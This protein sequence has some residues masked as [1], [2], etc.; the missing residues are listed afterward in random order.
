MPMFDQFGSNGGFLVIMQILSALQATA[1]EDSRIIRSQLLLLA[2]TILSDAITYSRA[3]LE[4]FKQMPGWDK[5]LDA[6]RFA[7]E[8]SARHGVVSRTSALLI[9]L[10][11]GDV[12]GGVQHFGTVYQKIRELQNLG[13]D[14]DA[15]RKQLTPL[16]Q[17]T[18]LHPRAIDGALNMAASDQGTI[19]TCYALLHDLLDEPRNIA[20]LS[21][22]ATVSRMLQ[23]WI[24]EESCSSSD[25]KLISAWRENLLRILLRDGIRSSDDLRSVFHQLQTHSIN[26]QLRVLNVMRSIAHDAYRPSALTF[27]PTSSPGGGG[28]YIASLNRAFPE[29]PESS[30]G[31]TMQ[32]VIRINRVQGNGIL[33]LVTLS[34]SLRLGMDLNSCQLIYHTDTTVSIPRSTLALR[35]W[36]HIVLTHARSK[37][38]SPAV[39]HVY[40]NG[41]RLTSFPAAYPASRDQV[42]VLLGSAPNQPGIIGAASASAS[43]SLSSFF[44]LDGVLPSSIPLLLTVLP[45][46]YKGNFQGRL[47][48]FL[49]PQG[50]TRMQLRL[51][52]LAAATANSNGKQA[53]PTESR[54]LTALRKALFDTG[55]EILPINRFYAH[56]QAAQTLRTTS[57]VFLQNKTLPSMH[58]TA[59]L[60][61]HHA[62]IF[63]V[64]TILVPRDVGDGIWAI[65]GVPCL[66]QIIERSSSSAALETCTCFFLE[67]VGRTWRLADDAERID[68]YSILGLLLRE[69][70]GMLT[71]AIL[72][73]LLDAC[74]VGNALCN[75]SLYRTVILDACLWA[76]APV[77][78]Q[79][80]YLAHFPKLFSGQFASYNA[81][82]LVRV[83]L[84]QTLLYFA[85]LASSRIHC[86]E[87]QIADA[88]QAVLQA[89]GSA[90]TIQAL[91]LFLITF[92]PPWSP[93]QCLCG[94]TKTDLDSDSHV[95]C[96]RALVPLAQAAPD[97]Q[98]ASLAH[99]LM[100]RF[101]DVTIEDSGRIERLA[102]CTSSRWILLLLRP[103][104]APEI[105]SQALVLT[106]KLLDHR[107]FMDQWSAHH[108]FRV[109]ERTLPLMWDEPEV[110]PSLW[111][112]LLGP[113]QEKAS[114]YAT[115]APQSTST[116]LRC[117]P[118][119]RIILQC[120]A[121]AI[122]NLPS[123]S[124]LRRASFSDL[125]QV[126]SRSMNN[127]LL[128]ESVQLLVEY[129]SHPEVTR[130][131]LLAPT[132]LCIFQ[133]I[134]PLWTSEKYVQCEVHE[135]VQRRLCNQLLQ[136]LAKQISHSILTSG[137]L[138]LL[139]TAHKAM[140][141][142]DPYY[143]SQLCAQIYTEVLR[144][145]LPL[146]SKELKDL[147]MVASLLKLAS[148]E[149]IAN[150]SLQTE[151][152]CGAAHLLDLAALQGNGLL[153]QRIAASVSIALRRNVLHSLYSTPIDAPSSPA[154]MFCATYWSSLDP[155]E[156][157]AQCIANRSIARISAIWD[158]DVATVLLL[159]NETH[160]NVIAHGDLSNLIQAIGDNRSI[161][162]PTV[163]FVD[164]WQL[165]VQDQD[166]F[167]RSLRMDRIR[168]LKMSLCRASPRAESLLATH[169]RMTQWYATI[170]EADRIRFHRYAQDLR[171]DALV[172]RHHWDELRISLQLQQGRPH[173][174]ALDSVEG[175][176]RMR[177]KLLPIASDDTV[178]TNSTEHPEVLSE[179]SSI[180]QE[181]V[182]SLSDAT[183]LDDVHVAAKVQARDSPTKEDTLPI[184][185]ADHGDSSKED[186]QPVDFVEDI[187]DTYRSILRS[188]HPSDTIQG[189]INVSRAVGVQARSCLLVGGTHHLYLFDDYFQR[190]NGDIVPIKHVSLSE[191]DKLV[192]AAFASAALPG[193][194]YGSDAILSWKWSATTLCL[195]R[196]WLHRNTAIELFFA[197]GQSCLLLLADS[198]DFDRALKLLRS[199]ARHAFIQAEAIAD[200]L[201]ELPIGPPA[202]QRITGALRRTNSIGATMRAWQLGHISNA[203]YLMALN[204]SAGR[205]LNDLTQYPVF[206]WVLADY[207]S[208]QLDLD[209]KSSFRDMSRPMGA[210]TVARRKESIERY[211]QLLEVHM[212]PFHYG[213]HYST[214]ASVCGF[215]VRLRPFAQWF[216]ELQ[217]GTFDL[218]DRMFASVHRAW[219]SA[220]QK[221]RGDVRELIPE[222]FY[223]PE[224]FMN[225][226]QF[227][228][229][230][231]Q[232]GVSV[233]DVE[234][235]PWAHDDPWL[236]VQ[237][238]REAL[239]SPWISAHLPLWID[240][241]FGYKAQGQAAV[242][243][244]NVFHPL[245]YAN[246]VDIDKIA[247]PME[248]EATAQV[249]HNFGQTPRNIFRHPHPARQIKQE[250]DLAKTPHLLISSRVPLAQ[251]G[252]AIHS[253]VGTLP[254]IR[255]GRA[256]EVLLPNAVLDFALPNGSIQITTESNN[257]KPFIVEQLVSSRIT[258][259]T[260]IA[261]THIA[262]GA[263]DGTVQL[264]ALQSN[265]CRLDLLANWPGHRQSVLCATSS[266]AWKLV[267]TG[268]TDHSAMVWDVTRKRHLRTLRGHAQAVHHVAIDDE[269]GWIATAAG[270]EICVWSM[271]GHL[272]LRQSTRS[273]T[274][275][276]L[277]S[278]AF[279]ARDFHSGCLAIVITGHVGQV[280]IWRVVSNHE[281]TAKH[282]P[283]WRLELQ[284]SLPARTQAAI[285]AMKVYQQ[286]K[287]CTADEKGDVY[288]WSLPGAALCLYSSDS[289]CMNEECGKR[290]GFLEQ[291]R[292]CGCCGAVFCS[293]CTTP[294]QSTRICIYCAQVLSERGLEMDTKRA[295]LSAHP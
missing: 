196:A 254:S 23:I 198:E 276:A 103:G 83:H 77:E 24:E 14:V 116:S 139:T 50:R 283:R 67:L 39:V 220:S 201:R 85:R 140:P 223:L 160:P 185:D 141:T 218:A 71:E 248:R 124:H 30:D 197:D 112:M 34:N 90:K 225:S 45:P 152:F 180:A 136:M 131:L 22:S 241:V 113:R 72:A 13:E 37:T 266:A 233:D 84:L 110:F 278:L 282:V 258:T 257:G 55:S 134:M 291:K 202:T 9:G 234:L 274:R 48:D 216:I 191:R 239:E 289:H 31:F 100:A 27:S 142:S 4:N 28:A 171:D 51:D 287:L 158:S 5:F 236:F 211:Q 87:P 26:H 203:A 206:P 271:N 130:I 172:A 102:Q 119:L 36:H 125:S 189:T 259:I 1:Q 260:A 94:T 59:Q 107:R 49:T 285:T 231:T 244:L 66:L 175:P 91:L 227:A 80:A 268:G 52:Q 262:V 193:G 213:T 207:T 168:Q 129:A 58:K 88:I 44:L 246:T 95:E 286:D 151:I 21:R 251:H 165:A 69:K 195:R 156:E 120:I 250:A 46:Q 53:R 18:V 33:N 89:C 121:E 290:F 133:S 11:M 2:I 8:A 64:P 252:A 12:A 270:D 288:I 229:G 115:F 135:S 73:A 19:L 145:L 275:Q 70:T 187:G 82:Q 41:Q 221:A 81:N 61:L 162:L 16:K 217:G 96:A 169:S 35:K 261:S 173:D 32:L 98:L 20:V 212:D 137:T 284:V 188:L 219:D 111:R 215:L 208:T 214:A 164:A 43:W 126:P 122:A 25:C 40:I 242:D 199:K 178:P 127:V 79:I 62:R 265:P 148:N 54:A 240:L 232:A 253:L 249:I 280:L 224:M 118:A 179:L 293:A 222:F 143:Q 157:F 106:E 247:S 267:V 269:R 7:A 149:S 108:G 209:A 114:L 184:Y 256:T 75:R 92:L 159:L 181:E 237:R 29:T 154:F 245:S 104:I 182:G 68:A 6:L 128:Q 230:R 99:V 155:D 279:C 238:N 281:A 277:T 123:H 150:E 272:L 146:R 138:S 273:A 57:G 167:Q 263:D 235:P 109:L 105:A 86:W 153:P 177:M 176:R 200:Q 76:Q 192:T 56:L 38:Q 163:P 42:S 101:M 78:V 255:A 243:A 97:P 190:P 15:V 132:L 144:C 295:T 63:G 166:E 292:T 194:S 294:H 228:L 47:S 60:S 174:W 210:Q 93:P 74:D 226:N 3:N 10:A 264:Y 117:L 186:V 205:T 65:G 161:S 147:A 204:N 17:H 183:M 170:T